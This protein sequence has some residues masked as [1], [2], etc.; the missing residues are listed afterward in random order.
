M[1]CLASL[2]ERIEIIEVRTEKKPSSWKRVWSEISN[3]GST[4]S[5]GR[6]RLYPIK[7]QETAASD[8]LRL[9]YPR[10]EVV[11]KT[12]KD[13]ALYF[14]PF[15][16]AAAARTTLRTINKYFQLRTCKGPSFGE[17]YSTL[18]PTSDR[19]L[20]RSLRPAG[21]GLPTSHQSIAFP[22]RQIP[23]PFGAPERK[24]VAGI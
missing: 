16:S 3:L 14:G 19:T 1:G 7:N 18:P 8:R 11:R 12:E 24:N 20:P 5:S 2:L 9:Q 21:H 13:K 17:P 15:V 22:E 10:L 4:S 6:Q 23:R